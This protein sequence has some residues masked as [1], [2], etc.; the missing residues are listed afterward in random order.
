ME[1]YDYAVD[2]FRHFAPIKVLYRRF[3]MEHAVDMLDEG[4]LNVY[5]TNILTAIR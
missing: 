1:L 4:V 3:Q 2:S 5:K